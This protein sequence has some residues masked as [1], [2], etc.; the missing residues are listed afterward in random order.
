MRS[1]LL[2][3]F[4]TLVNFLLIGAAVSLGMLFLAAIVGEPAGTMLRAHSLFPV[5]VAGFAGAAGAI[6]VL[7]LPRRQG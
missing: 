3:A 7:L 6:I 5:A 1:R 2:S 4:V